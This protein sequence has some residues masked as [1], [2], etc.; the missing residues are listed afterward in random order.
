MSRITVI[1]EED[2]DDFLTIV[3]NAYSRIPLSTKEEREKMKER[4][5]A[6]LKEETSHLYGLYREGTLQGGM[7][8]YDFTM[9]IRSVKMLAGGVGLVA[10]DLAHKRE[11]VCK[12]MITF[13]LKYY[14][15]RG[16]CMTLLYPFSPDFYKKMGFGFGTKMN[17]YTVTPEQLPRGK[18]DHIQFIDTTD[19]KAMLD[20]YTRYTEKT[21]G[22]I[23]MEEFYLD[24]M[25]KNPK[26]KVV[27][28]KKG[29][30]IYGY[31]VFTFKEGDAE[32]FLINDIEIQEFLYETREALSELL[33]FLH[34][35]KDQIRYIII[36]TLDEYFHHLLSDPRD[37]SEHIIPD[38]YH[39]SN[40]SGVGIM[41]RVIDTEKLFTLLKDHNF[42]NQ[43]C[44]LKISVRDSFLPDHD[45]SY[46]VHF[47]NGIPS[48]AQKG[49]DV[50]VI[51]DVSDF[52]SLVMGVVP[53]K[54][55]Y[56]YTAAEISDPTYVDTVTQLFKTKEK[57]VCTT[58]F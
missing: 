57:P 9:N 56:Q 33:T 32:N 35:Q 41:Y 53:F 16:S 43:S 45:G 23:D 24:R 21:H 37:S 49:Y 48:V 28:Y 47:D 36:N 34:T 50:E 20:C 22:M 4:L 55:L 30:T 52:S 29:D 14:R 42:G 46:I 31:I 18:K 44:K 3:A 7:I 19:K 25:V 38:V 27:A 11:K 12:E 15:E 39:E 51:L 5:I 2:I 17:Q 10:V 13:F 58:R 54:R 26:N 1:P 40:V 6:L 8:L